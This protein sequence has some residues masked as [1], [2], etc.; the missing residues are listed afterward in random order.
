MWFDQSWLLWDMIPLNDK[1]NII[2]D[3]NKYK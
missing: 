1:K 2:N 3:R